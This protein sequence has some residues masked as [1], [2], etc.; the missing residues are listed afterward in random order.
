[1]DSWPLI[2]VNNPNNCENRKPLKKEKELKW[3]KK[4]QQKQNLQFK[5]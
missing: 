3:W 1:M 5:V 4:A 2:N